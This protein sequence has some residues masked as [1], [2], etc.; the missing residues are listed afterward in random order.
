MVKKQ[1]MV[2]PPPSKPKSVKPSDLASILQQ[3]G[4]DRAY[5]I[6]HS[7]GKSWRLIF[8]GDYHL[9]TIKIVDGKWKIIPD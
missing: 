6:I 4:N 8:E 9:S 3:L 2:Q 5:T 1:A 7:D